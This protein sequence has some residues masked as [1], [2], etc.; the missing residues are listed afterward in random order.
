MLR[1]LRPILFGS[2][3]LAT[4][5]VNAVTIPYC[6]DPDWMPYEGIDQGK[7]VGISSGFL[8]LIE[9]QTD[10]QFQLV[11]TDSW[12]QT[13][14]YLKQQRCVFTTMLNYT[15][16]RAE[17][18]YFSDIY[19]RSPNVLV[20]RREQPFL[21]NMEQVGD[22]SLAIPRGYRLLDYVRQNYPKIRII[23]AE[24][25]Q[26]G[27]EMVSSGEADLFIGSMYSI[28][29]RIQQSG[30]FNLKIAAWAGPEEQFR[31]AVTENSKW[32]LPELNRLLAQISDDYR[33]RLYRQWSNIAVLKQTD[34]GLTWQL[35]VVVTLVFGALL[36][37][38]RWISKY[39][40]EL[41]AKN[42]QLE[43]LRNQLL[44]TNRELEFISTHDPLTKLYNR[45]YFH[46]HFAPEHRS[47]AMQG[48]TSLI[49]IDIDFFK[50][51]NDRHGHS[52]G[53]SILSDLA[54]LLMEGAREIDLVARW[55]GEEFMIVCPDTDCVQARHLCERLA[56]AMTVYPF[57]AGVRL[58]CSFGLTELKPG[59]SIWSAFDRADQALYRA[60]SE[61]RNR[62]CCDPEYERANKI[63]PNS[64]V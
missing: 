56:S 41:T 16:R 21:Q 12:Q 29:A 24:T 44:E 52:V 4:A 51:I 50:D 45:H 27:L 28:N 48:H 25:E 14:A 47:D 39:N 63:G 20:S 64:S 1:F 23:L 7:H 53:D 36:A 61:G 54:S 33:A 57:S 49:V 60:K 13:L 34:R 10:W 19:S 43:K 9:E 42:Q 32:M 22:R 62:I 38:Y 11:P 40:R 55:G 5:A 6:V 26:Q 35:L 59:E 3:L 37:R 2:L 31:M 17:F 30:L 18:L 58:S 8:E 15:P 46:R